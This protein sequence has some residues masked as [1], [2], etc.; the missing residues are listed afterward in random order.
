MPTL[1]FAYG[2]N[3]S[4]LQMRERCPSSTFVGIGILRGWTWII[5]ARGYANLVAAPSSANG[6]C[7]DVIYGLVYELLPQD[8]SRLDGYEGVPWDYTKELHPIE[9]WEEETGANFPP[10]VKPGTMTQALVY[11]DRIRVER[12]HPKGEYIGRMRRGISEA[13]QKGIPLKWMEAVMGQFLPL[14][15]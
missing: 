9:L 4:L 10:L 6:T 2:S 14:E 12:D 15:D 3:L 5:N 7:N 11:I 13:A 8:E 1:Y